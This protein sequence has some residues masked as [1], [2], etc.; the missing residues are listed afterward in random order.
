MSER[1]ELFRL[2]VLQRRQKPL[3]PKPKTNREAY[4]RESFGTRRT[5]T[6]YG[7][8]F[9][10][11]PEPTELHDD[12]IIGR[13]GRSV[14][15]E[16]NQSPDEGFLETIHDGWK[17]SVV[18]IDPRE[19]ADGQKVA[20]S[21]DPKVGTPFGLIKELVYVINCAARDAQWDIEVESI[22]N[23][24]NFWDFAKKNEGEITSLVF[25]FVAPNMFGG[26]DD[27]SE[28]LRAFRREEN[29]QKITIAL[30][31]SD[32]L[33]TSTKRVKEGVDY[34]VKGCGTI[35]AK[36]KKRKSFNSTKKVAITTLERGSLPNETLL[37]KV[38]RMA[39]QVLGRE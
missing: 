24:Q 21:I 19:H 31:S 9:H 11:V 1:F 14:V 10:Y 39:T 34:A 27:L 37:E 20:I 28:E 18:V 7:T 6:F 2:S 32:G 4:L 35:T 12:V 16:E 5:F 26:S 22:I 23:P 36:T 25:D 33:D 30:K 3:F 38:K 29:A 15:I 13:I 17:A 8:E